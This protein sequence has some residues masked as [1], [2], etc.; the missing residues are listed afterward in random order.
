MPY[1]TTADGLTVTYRVVNPATLA[2]VTASTAAVAGLA[3]QYLTAAVIPDG[4]RVEWYEAG[5]YQVSED[6]PM[7]ASFAGTVT[8]PAVNTD[9][10]ATSLAP[11]M[12]APNPTTL[13]PAERT[14]IANAVVAVLPGT[15]PPLGYVRLSSADTN[16]DGSLKYGTLLPGTVLD[17]YLVGDAEF[18]T[19]KADNVTAAANGSWHIDV[20]ESAT[21]SLVGR[22][23]DKNATIQ[24]VTV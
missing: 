24:V 4:M 3:K 8:A 15:T 16:P 19:P 14:A 12:P 21:Y 18:A 23:P 1:D 13:A 5:V 22:R 2:V 7:S 20:P 9:A 10:L 6:V 11:L 17:A